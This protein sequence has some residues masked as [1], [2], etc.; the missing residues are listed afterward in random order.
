MVVSKIPEQKTYPDKT[1]KWNQGVCIDPDHTPPTTMP[2]Q[3]TYEHLCDN[4]KNL[5]I[6]VVGA[7]QGPT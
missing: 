4:C 6:F 7:K 1:G 5:T 2:E 3:G